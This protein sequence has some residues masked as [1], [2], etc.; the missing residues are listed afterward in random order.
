MRVS[1]RFTVPARSSLNSF[2]NLV[3]T[4]NTQS[5]AAV[6]SMVAP[7]GICTKRLLIAPSLHSVWPGANAC[8][9]LASVFAFQS[10]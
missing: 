3:P 6:V 5:F 7:C 8:T 1:M 9:P 2:Q 10:A 4:G